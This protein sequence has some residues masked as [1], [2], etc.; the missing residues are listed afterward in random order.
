MTFT[1]KIIWKRFFLLL[2]SDNQKEVN[3]KVYV[4]VEKESTD[5]HTVN[6]SSENTEDQIAEGIV[7]RKKVRSLIFPFN[8]S[9][10][11]EGTGQLLSWSKQP[12]LPELQ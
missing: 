4:I 12:N 5:N 11:Q 8:F 2:I 7:G 10:E 9:C 3:I 1:S 6:D